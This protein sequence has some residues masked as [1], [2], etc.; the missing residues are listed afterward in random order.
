MFYGSSSLYKLSD[1]S[2]WETKNIR[3]MNPMFI[4]CQKLKPLPDI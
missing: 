2:K 4:I 1:I 3:S